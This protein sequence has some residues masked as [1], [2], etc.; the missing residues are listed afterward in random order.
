MKNKMVK[1]NLGPTKPEHVLAALFIILFFISLISSYRLLAVTAFMVAVYSVIICENKFFLRLTKPVLPFVAL[2]LL[3]PLLSY[4]IHGTVKDFDFSVM[5]TC[6]ILISSIVLGTVVSKHSA[7]YLVDGILNIGLPP[8]L[9]R[10]F[11]LTFRYFHM[12]YG[13]V[14]QGKKALASRGIGERKG[15]SVLSIFG[16]WIGG[17]FL[18]S[19]Y[20]SDMVFNAMKSRGFEGEARNKMRGNK[21]LLVSSSILALFLT[22][23]L[24]IDGK[25]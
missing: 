8:V 13:D 19:S 24:M 6:K 22:I 4:A 20:H 5:I 21:G 23:I 14:D 3:P 10:I 9:N 1:L 17:F 25:L 16:Q 7:L 15:F 11:A 18:K 12:I 2:M